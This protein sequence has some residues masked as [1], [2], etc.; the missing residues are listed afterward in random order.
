MLEV[1]NRKRYFNEVRLAISKFFSIVS[2]FFFKVD[3]GK[4]FKS[5]FKS[6]LNILIISHFLLDSI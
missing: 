6:S 4:L 3:F 2:Y 5:Y 1:I